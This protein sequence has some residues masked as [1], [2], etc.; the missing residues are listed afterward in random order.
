MEEEDS[1]PAKPPPFC[2]LPG[3]FVWPNLPL[4]A[5]CIF[6]TGLT[7][8][9]TAL[10][11]WQITKGDYAP[12]GNKKFYCGPGCTVLAAGILLSVLC[13]LLIMLAMLLHFWRR[14]RKAS[15]RPTREQRLER[16]AFRGTIGDQRARS[17]T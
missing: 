15:W 13:V 3:I 7:K 12:G 11:A 17:A 1:E 16:P 2:R 6:L 10:L 8:K 14:F 5:F 4:F 9:S